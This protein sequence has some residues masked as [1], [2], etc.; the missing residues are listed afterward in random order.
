MLARYRTDTGLRVKMCPNSKIPED[1]FGG[2]HRQIPERRIKGKK[3]QREVKSVTVAV[4]S[5]GTLG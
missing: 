3:L 4:L 1:F 5:R 2:F